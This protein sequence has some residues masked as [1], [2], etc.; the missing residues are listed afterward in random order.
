MV[1]IDRLTCVFFA[2]LFLISV[3]FGFGYY[4]QKI[5]NE[6]QNYDKNEPTS[7]L[8]YQFGCGHCAEVMSNPA[9]QEYKNICGIKEIQITEDI[10]TLV[11]EICNK[12]KVLYVNP[13]FYVKTKNKDLVLCGKD[14]IPEL[15]CRV[16]YHYCG[17]DQCTKIHPDY[18]KEPMSYEK[19]IKNRD[20]IS[21]F[22]LTTIIAATD[23][24]NP[25]IISILAFLLSQL[26]IAGSKKEVLKYGSMYIIAV[27]V[28]YLL[29]GLIIYSLGVSIAN[30]K[31]YSTIKPILVSILV[32]GLLI[33]GLIN[34]KDYFAYGVGISFRVP[35][36]F[37]PL[38][39]K[40]ATQFTIS[41]VIILAVL[42]TIIEFPCSGAMYAG[43]CFLMSQ[44]N[45]SILEV[46]IWLIYYNIIFVA[47]LILCTALV[48]KGL[49]VKKIDEFRLKY[50]HIARLIMGLAFVLLAILY[51]AMYF[52]PF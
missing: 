49:D 33:F 43:W 29:L 5:I 15:K 21:M 48:Y 34:I 38:I 39:K 35:D 6:I 13:V 23:S 3:I 2:M 25:C 32:I 14:I 28:S 1:N 26:L 40:Y 44:F 51:I 9:Y 36:Q 7:Y 24:I 16:K 27:F 8:F 30:L 37:K 20:W 45:Y 46:L 42:V 22:I 4:S 19:L 17:V 47:P 31:L 12:H 10:Q 50:R 18:N 52:I 11:D 41:G